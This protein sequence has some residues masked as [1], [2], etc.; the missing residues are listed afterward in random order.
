ME[1]PDTPCYISNSVVGNC[2]RI[3]RSLDHVLGEQDALFSP[4]K[5][6]ELDPRHVISGDYH[7]VVFLGGGW[8][9]SAV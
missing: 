3:C 7:Y 9:I 6:I 4:D 8:E 5:D 1:K 2:Y